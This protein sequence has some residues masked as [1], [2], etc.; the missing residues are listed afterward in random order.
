[1]SFLDFLAE[2]L[3]STAASTAKKRA[4]IARDYERK[5]P[6]MSSEQRK[7]L[8]EYNYETEKIGSMG[9]VY[10]STSNTSGSR[11]NGRI[12]NKTVG[13]WDSEWVSIGRLK[14]ANLSPYNHCVGLYK[15]V[16]NG[17][18]KYIGR[19]IELHNGGFRKRL[20]DY[21]RDSNSGRKHTSGRV[22]YEHIGEIETYILIVGTTDEAV[23]ATRKLEGLFIRK[24]NPPW[25][26]MINI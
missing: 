14:T 7:K 18:T 8:D 1:M 23:E 16:I 12:L 15:H 21:R 3:R 13:Q 9:G 6:N 4:S 22:I 26:K 20:S 19:A 25:N 17:E 5:H 10:V 2:K 24:Y 11:T